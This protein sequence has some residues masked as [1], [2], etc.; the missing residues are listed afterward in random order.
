GRRW[1]STGPT[2][3]ATRSSPA[4]P[5]P[6]AD[7]RG[8]AGCDEVRDDLAVAAVGDFD[9][10]RG[11]EAVDAP[12]V[13]QAFSAHRLRIGRPVVDVGG[14]RVAARL[15]EARDIVEYMTGRAGVQIG[16]GGF[17]Q[18]RLLGRRLKA[19]LVELLYVR[20][21]DRAFAKHEL[22]FARCGA[23]KEFVVDRLFG[24]HPWHA[25]EVEAG[26]REVTQLRRGEQKFVDV[27]P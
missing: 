9:Q 8:D 23:D 14:T 19:G 11:L 13:A 4:R 22:A 24:V 12:A 25:V 10:N 7:P 26:P 3:T 18:Q 15:H 2:P 1:C 20:A 6:S 5:S 17:G 21:E 16:G 27:H